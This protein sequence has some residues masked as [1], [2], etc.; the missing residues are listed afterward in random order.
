M[1]GPLLM[2]WTIAYT[3]AHEVNNETDHCT[4]MMWQTITW[5]T[6]PGVVGDMNRYV[7]NDQRHRSLFVKGSVAQI[8]EDGADSGLDHCTWIRCWHGSLHMQ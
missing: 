4:W 3:T 5:S 2:K 1:H 7:N 8:T 6:A